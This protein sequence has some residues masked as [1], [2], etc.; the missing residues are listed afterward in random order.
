[1]DDLDRMLRGL[2]RAA[3]PPDLAASIREAVR[4]RHR[5]QL[6]MRRI[7]GAALAAMGL[8]LLW[9]ALA[10]MSSGELFA[11]GAPWL[12][13]GLDSLNSESLD[14]LSRLWNG[15]V[16]MQ[17]AV[18]SGLALSILLGAAFVCCSIF[19]AIDRAA[20]LTYPGRGS[21]QAGPALSAPGIHL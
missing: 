8:W 18:G 13:G 12:M 11:S 15:T 21:L 5:R 20:W 6:L 3:L 1:M 16:S 19:L 4:R 7:I 14:L 9:P 2:P 10:W 17:G